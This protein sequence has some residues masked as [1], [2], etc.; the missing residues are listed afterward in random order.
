MFA[1]LSGA[2][3]K[4]DLAAGDA[5]IKVCICVCVYVYICVYV[6]V[7]MC[8]CRACVG[9]PC[10]CV[11]R[12]CC[13][14][15]CWLWL[16]VV[17][18]TCPHCGDVAGVARSCG[19][20]TA[21]EADVLGGFL[22]GPHH[23]GVR[24]HTSLAHT[25]ALYL[26]LALTTPLAL[27]LALVLSSYLSSVVFLLCLLVLTP[28]P[29][30]VPLCPLSSLGLSSLLAFFF[31]RPPPSSLPCG[32]SV[33]RCRVWTPATVPAAHA[34]ISQVYALCVPCVCP[35]YCVALCGCPVWL[36]CVCA[37]CVPCVYAPCVPFIALAVYSNIYN[38]ILCTVY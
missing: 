29:L 36:P 5:R 19:E 35:V 3:A 32:T 11:R 25:L 8:V 28:P 16:C 12:L 38:I 22:S 30:G 4:K 37:L 33:A 27:I 20:Y 31:V 15:C 9:C 26:I 10:S 14:R 7:Y 34:G 6:C 17:D 23:Q 2:V 24:A 13:V 1:R 21:P 18:S